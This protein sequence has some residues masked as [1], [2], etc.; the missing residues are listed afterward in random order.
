V[1]PE[2][3]GY[4]SVV[5]SNAAGVI[6][7]SN[8]LLSLLDSP[9]VNAVQA[10]PGAR[11]A[12]ISWNTTVPAN[13]EVQYDIGPVAIPNGYA[14]ASQG[15]FTSSSYIDPALTTN[16]VI[17]LTGLQPGTRYNFQ[18]ISS[19][20]TNNY[21]SGVYQFSTAGAL[22]IDNPGARLTGLWTVSN[23]STDRYSTDYLSATAVSG[24]ATATA[25]FRPNIT[26]PGKYNVYTWYPQGANQ[27]NNTPLTISFNGGSMT[28]LV[29]QQTGGGLWRLVASGVEFALG[30]NGFVQIANNADPGVVIADAV[31]FDYV[32]SQDFPS[33]QDIPPWWQNFFFGGP[34]DPNA[35]PDHDGY[36]TAQ[37]YV[38]G[39][40]P[41]NKDSRL[42]FSGQNGSNSARITFW[43]FLAN[44]AYQLLYRPEIG[45]PTWQTTTLSNITLLP[46]G[47]GFF[48]LDITNA[49]QNYYRL[50][51][52]LIT[53]GTFSGSLPVPEGKSYSPFASEPLCGPNRAYIR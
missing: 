3:V 30:T 16:H 18:V 12:L 10:V 46:D 20:D 14:A 4:Y 44:R 35:D 49:P 8:A 24:A 39:T 37:E 45:A 15:G 25:T 11:S 42:D 38:M 47:H 51:V 41:T 48:A 28:V 50:K 22:I 23:T 34:A 2:D 1:Q 43:P 40:S 6:T 27:A 21:I 7:S 26:T 31:R 9:Y 17:L 5:I 53:N 19:I 29:N 33:G 13:S 36:T 32:E 52:Q